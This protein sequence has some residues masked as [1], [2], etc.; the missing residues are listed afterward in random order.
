MDSYII[1]KLE[2]PDVCLFIDSKSKYSG[3]EKE[4]LINKLNYTYKNLV[5]LDDVLDL[6]MVELDNFIVPARNIY[7][8]TLATYYGDE[9]ILGATYVIEVQI[10]IMYLK[11]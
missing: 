2:K 8:A 6:S 10:K 7:F 5:I 1:D 3:V 9:I 11:V 4:W